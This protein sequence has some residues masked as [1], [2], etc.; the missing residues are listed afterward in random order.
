MSIDNQSQ[1]RLP[2]KTPVIAIVAG[3][4]SGDQYGAMIMQNLKTIYPDCKFIGVGG[5]NMLSIGLESLMDMEIL[6]T[7]GIIDVIKK[8][9]KLIKAKNKLVQ[10]I[11]HLKPNCFIGI[12]CPDFNLPVAKK[13]KKISN[14]LNLNIKTVQYI[15][16]TVWA[17]RPGRVHTVAKAV[18]KVLCIFPFEQDIYS[19]NNI[20]AD[21]VGHPLSDT[22]KPRIINDI[23]NAK[24]KLNLDQNKK[25]V[26]IYPGSRS[27]EIKYLAPVFL[28]AVKIFGQKNKE[29]KYSYMVPIVSQKIE[30]LWQEAFDKYQQ[31]DLNINL[32]KLYDNKNIKS[33][34]IMTAA[35]IILCSSGTTTM[36]AFLLNIPM[37]V[38]Y[39]VSKLNELLLKYL[40]KVNYIA[41]PNIISDMKLNKNL[42]PEFVQDD[43][44][45]ENLAEALEAELNKYQ[46]NQT[47]S[48]WAQL[49]EYM[50][51]GNLNHTEAVAG[52]VAELL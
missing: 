42:V 50:S 11:I 14:K 44:T 32:I 1:I 2:N 20:K 41:M 37:V 40:I 22:L 16:P 35:E 23:V 29:N 49:Q 52:Q 18:D 36:E 26:A 4:H 48:T 33:T 34:D 25:Y 27:S 10:D 45:A 21:F 17:W 9:P 8:L 24:A 28:E 6:S 38:A 12:D 13:I 15:S 31:D 30:T 7:I 46:N 43:V 3:E 5:S 51:N 19:K 47:N 39:K